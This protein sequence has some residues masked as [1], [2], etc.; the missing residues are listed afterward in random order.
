MTGQ[1]PPRGSNAARRTGPALEACYQFI[2]W[3]APTVEKFPRSQKFTL[4]DRILGAAYDVLERLIEATYARSRRE[5]LLKANLDLQ[6]LRILCRLALDLG[7]LDT[8]RFEHAMR[9]IDTIGR[10]IGGW[11]KASPGAAGAEVDGQEL[12][13][14][15][16]GATRPQAS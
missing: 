9:Q 4:G 12:E 16:H 10:L 14:Q 13:E 6:K 3:L 11:M 2:L 7:H 15:A 5:L 8:R 1:T